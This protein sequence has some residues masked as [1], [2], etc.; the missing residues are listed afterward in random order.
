[1]YPPSCT[2]NIKM[3]ALKFAKFSD[4]NFG[5]RIK[6]PNITRPEAYSC[7]QSQIAKL[8]HLSNLLKQEG[9]PQIKRIITIFEIV[10]REATYQISYLQLKY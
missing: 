2:Q 9:H 10:F 4:I 6:I 3:H 5:K 1:M 8:T 7:A